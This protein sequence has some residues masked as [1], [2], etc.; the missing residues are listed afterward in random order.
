MSHD[1]VRALGIL[2]PPGVP[3]AF[4]DTRTEAQE[5]VQPWLD[6]LPN[7]VRTRQ[8]TMPITIVRG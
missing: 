7:E 3:Y 2:Q 6:A 8:P 4:V 5:C 1:R